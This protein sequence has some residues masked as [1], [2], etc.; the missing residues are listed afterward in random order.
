VVDSDD[1]IWL[2]LVALV[3]ELPTKGLSRLMNA[4]ELTRETELVAH[5]G[6][7]GDDAFEFMER[8]AARFGVEK[9]DYDSSTYFEAE[10]LWLL[11]RLRKQ[12]P[13]MRITL[14]MLELAAQ[15]GEWNCAKLHRLSG[16]SA[17][18]T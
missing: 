9:G 5:L 16:Q 6:L 4:K 7:V 14:G 3:E 18:Q 1:T 17:T 15:D 13:K 2:R 11:P 8:Y 12:K 10:G